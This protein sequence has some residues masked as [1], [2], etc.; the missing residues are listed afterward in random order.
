MA[1]GTEAESEDS[2]QWTRGLDRY[3]HP[4][5]HGENRP[6]RAYEGESASA[7]SSSRE[8]PHFSCS[9]AVSHEC[10]KGVVMDFPM[11]CG[12]VNLALIVALEIYDGH[13]IQFGKNT[14]SL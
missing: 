7:V 12:H 10:L 3:F 4:C 6:V 5:R 14:E 13:E 9:K 2:L 8:S 1:A 11:F